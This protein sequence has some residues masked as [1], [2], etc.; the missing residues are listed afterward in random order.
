MTIA[1]AVLD[2]WTPVRRGA[3]FCSPGCG[4]G[5]TWEAKVHADIKGKWLANVLNDSWGG[6]WV[7]RVHENLGWHWGARTRYMHV[8][9]VIDWRTRE[10]IKFM[11][12]LNTVE[13]NIGGRWCGDG[14]TPALA[15]RGAVK[16]LTEEL[17]LLAKVL[18]VVKL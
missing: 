13:D 5:C 11:C 15:V 9:P 3:I 4:G 1:Q 2:R 6:V 10:P 7:P 8:S 18:K 16:L 12:L 14:K 17:A